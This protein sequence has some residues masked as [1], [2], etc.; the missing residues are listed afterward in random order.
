MALVGTGGIAFLVANFVVSHSL[1]NVDGPESCDWAERRELTSLEHTT[2]SVAATI[3]GTVESGMSCSYGALEMQ[4]RY[5]WGMNG[6]EV[7]ALLDAAGGRHPSRTCP[8]IYAGSDDDSRI[9]RVS[10]NEECDSN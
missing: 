6:T 8:M 7:S 2:A 10:L 5:R 1:R 3:G 4:V 9:V